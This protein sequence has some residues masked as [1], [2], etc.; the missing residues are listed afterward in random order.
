MKWTDI[1]SEWINIRQSKSSKA[2]RIP[3][4]AVAAEVIRTLPSRGVYL[5]TKRD[6]SRFFPDSYLRPLQRA[7]KRAGIKKRIDLHTLRHSYGSNKLRDGWGLKKVSILLGHSSIEVTARVYA[8]LLD[9]DLRVRDEHAISTRN[10]NQ[11]SNG[12]TI[13]NIGSGN[14]L[15]ILA[16]KFTEGFSETEAGR[17][18]LLELIQ[19][20]ERL[21]NESSSA[22]KMRDLIRNVIEEVDLHPGSKK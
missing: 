2:R 13:D 12:E 1:D 6:G 8:H 22:K 4:E 18:A 16:E 17:V 19:Q 21:P 14:V 11:L 3:L 5:F 7:A 9:G 15:D 10:L 20:L